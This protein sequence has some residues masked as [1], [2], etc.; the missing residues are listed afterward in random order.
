[1]YIYIYLEVV[2]QVTRVD[3]RTVYEDHVVWPSLR[4]RR[5]KGTPIV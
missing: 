1:M 3:E 4:W 2:Q 5:G